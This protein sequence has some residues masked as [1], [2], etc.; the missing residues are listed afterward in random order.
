M[1][2]QTQERT[3][4]AEADSI[5]APV[6]VQQRGSVG[7]ALSARA[8]ALPDLIAWENLISFRPS[9]AVQK[10][11]ERDWAPDWS[12]HRLEDAYGDINL[13]FYPVTITALPGPYTAARLLEQIRMDFNS[14]IDTDISEFAPYDSGHAATWEKADPTGAV[15]H[16]DMKMWGG[17]VNPDDGSVVCAERKP[18]HWIFSTIWT[19]GDFGHPVS[20]NR[21][22][23]YYQTDSGYVFYTRGADRATGALDHAISGKMFT[24][25]DGLWRSLQNGIAAFVNSKGG[26]ATVNARHWERYDWPSVELAYHHPIET[27][28]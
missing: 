24:A 6:V 2:E 14:F 11:L 27:W 4:I 8:L 9:H 25:A 23:G 17:W 16:I 20:G 5:E 26:S 13:D 3:K 21:Q 18:D 15:I 7:Q 22:F 28:L 19:P 10:S 12:V 1:A